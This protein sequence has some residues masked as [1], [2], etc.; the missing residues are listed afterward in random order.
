MEYKVIEEDGSQP[1]IQINEVMPTTKDLKLYFSR[2]K[3]TINSRTIIF[4]KTLINL[5]NNLSV[6]DQ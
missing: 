4:L 3:L 6:E 2:W 1:F 5:L